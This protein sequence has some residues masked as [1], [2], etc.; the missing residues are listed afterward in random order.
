MIFSND[1]CNAYSVAWPVISFPIGLR[2]ENIL[3]RNPNERV[4]LTIIRRRNKSNSNLYNF[5]M[6][7]N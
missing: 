3:G 5:I 2:K 1:F 7:V 6:L 4:V